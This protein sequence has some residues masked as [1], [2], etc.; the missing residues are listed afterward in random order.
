MGQRAGAAGDA[1]AITVTSAENRS[2]IETGSLS[3]AGSPFAKKGALLLVI[4]R[5]PFLILS[6]V[7]RDNVA[8]TILSTMVS[9]FSASSSK[10]V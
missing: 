2:V 6:A 1:P 4:R 5:V 7:Q 8:A 3:V 10:V 9:S